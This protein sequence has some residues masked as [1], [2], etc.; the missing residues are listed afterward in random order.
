[1]NVNAIELAAISDRC[2]IL[3]NR[4]LFSKTKKLVENSSY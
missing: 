2:R 4:A 3:A 1:M